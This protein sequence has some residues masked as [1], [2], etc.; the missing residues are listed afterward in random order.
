MQLVA[1]KRSPCQ[2]PGMTRLDQD[3]FARPA[4]ELAPALL[5]KRISLGPVIARITEVEAYV[6][7]SDSANHCFKGKTPRNAP[8]WGPPG[9][10]YVYLCYGIHHLRNVVSDRE[11]EG[12]AVLIRSVEV[13]SGFDVVAERRNG[14]QGPD[15]GAGPGNV[16]ALLGLDRTFNHHPVFEKGGLEFHDAPEFESVLR[17]PRVGIGYAKPKDQR[18]RWRF[19]LAE[20][21]AIS[22][23][24]SLKPWR[25]GSGRLS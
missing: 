8:M 3:F 18:A 10:A 24:K 9:H 20:T 13:L 19:A 16:G 6:A 7:Q 4:L 25:M 5:G 14:R 15:V 1:A 2:A 21:A 23:K 22:Q 17:G 11:G 12:A